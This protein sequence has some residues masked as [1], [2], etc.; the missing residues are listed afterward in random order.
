MLLRE[1][2]MLSPKITL[3]YK[4]K[5][6]HAS[7]ISGILTI[8]VYSF[9][10][11]FII[12]YFKDY[13]NKEN[14]TAYFFNRYV[15]D[16]GKFSFSK[17]YFFNYVRLI[18]SKSREEVPFDFDKV[19]IIGTNKIISDYLNDN[20]GDNQSHWIY[21]KCEDKININ[22]INN[23]LNYE[24]FHKSACLKY[25]YSKEK[26][27]YYDI[28]DR[29]FIWP[30]IDHGASHINT[31][32]FGIILKKCENS[33]FRLNNFGPCSSEDEIDNYIKSIYLS[34]TIIDQYVDIL[35]Y[36]NPI[37]S[38]LYS[39]TNGIAKDSYV[40]NNLNFDP[41]LIRTYDNIFSDKPVEKTAYFFHQN[42][43][44][45]TVSTNTKIIGAFYIWMQ[46]S[47]QYYERRYKKLQDFLSDIGGIANLI[48]V[49][50]EC[51]NYFIARHNM[52]ADTQELISNII[53]KNISIYE[54]LIKSHNPKKLININN[55]KR[56]E[57]NS[58]L[59]I[60][61]MNKNNKRLI[62]TENSEIRKE[63]N[64]NILGNKI[65]VINNDYSG[66]EKNGIDKSIENGVQQIN[67]EK[68]EEDLGKLKRMSTRNEIRRDFSLINE[69]EKFNCFSYLFYI[70]FCKK[71]NSN[72]KYYEELRRLIISEECMIQ[73][74]LNI[75]KLLEIQNIT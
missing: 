61:D 23:L 7:V 12:I 52:L 19:E 49:V 18:N 6:T 67:K 5:N 43:K 32:F 30:S 15:D 73:N 53:K 46:N 75:Y 10:I 11:S 9:I 36:E 63:G 71:I 62:S 31:T 65:K 20:D 72:I 21:G 39:I 40:T 38:Y 60:F 17:N 74:Y 47:Q 56:N 24:D 22:E 34:F 27:R 59:K 28:N 41:G 64:K 45:T 44:S 58:S 33:T 3:Y 48:L 1:I 55:Q 4:Q 2:D 37:T 35:N 66:E 50:A 68:S 16:I 25:Y 42:S 69:K 29:N 70:C 8:I 51:I 57:D 13:I 54:N 26:R 14:P